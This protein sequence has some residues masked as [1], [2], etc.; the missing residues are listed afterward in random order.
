[1]LPFVL[2][3]EAIASFGENIVLSKIA[4]IRKSDDK[5]S[6]L[7]SYI[8]LGGKVGVIIELKVDDAGMEKTE[9][10]KEFI[11]NVVL[12][13]ASMDPI[14]V[15]RENVPADIIEEQKDI[16]TK[17]AR[18]SGKPEKIIEKIVEGRLEK[19]FAQM[20]LLEQKYVKDGDLTV[21][22]YLRQTEQKIKGK[23]NIERFVRFK[24]GEE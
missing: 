11:K 22:E 8:H 15:S 2:S 6:V 9:D 16:L 3:L 4:R 5:R 18:D 7:N 10:F 12:Q 13:I 21:G 19:F 23:I 20:C 1:M 14:S 24:L 17:Q